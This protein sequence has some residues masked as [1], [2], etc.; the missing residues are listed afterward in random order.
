MEVT[1]AESS[2]Q[3][4]RRDLHRFLDFVFRVE[5]SDE[6][7]VW[8]K[9]LSRAFLEELRSQVKEGGGRY[10]SDRTLERI[11]AHLKTFAKW[12]H[13]VAPFPLGYPLE[14]LKTTTPG[15]GLET[16]RA[17]TP[18]ERR[19]LLDA[20]DYLPVLGGRSKDRRHQ[21][22]LPDE[23][24]RRKGYRPWRNRAIVYALVETGMRRAAAVNL[25]LSDV[26]FERS[27]VTV[28]EKGGFRHCYKIS[29]EGLKAIQDYLPEE[30][31]TDAD[32]WTDSPALFLP[33]DSKPQSLGRLTPQVVN[34]VWNE[35][36]ALA[37]IQG[38]T[39]TAIAGPAI[40][41]P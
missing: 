22:K 6:R 26:D 4:Q 36:S 2:R 21:A 11:I 34:A 40:G 31:M 7:R 17:I 19:K 23:R 30:R 41:T 1:T 27:A 28:P 15:T 12:I 13:K 33:A 37:G 25:D 16:E 9:R 39:P 5:G 18:A 32:F 10:Y 38:K 24:P 14:K 29:R 8:T 20:A 3:V 35:V